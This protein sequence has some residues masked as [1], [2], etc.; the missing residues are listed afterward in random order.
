MRDED[1]GPS[2]AVSSS[3]SCFVDPW[4]VRPPVVVSSPGL[5]LAPTPC[6]PDT[7]ESHPSGADL[8]VHPLLLRLL[9]AGIPRGGGRGAATGRARCALSLCSGGGAAERRGRQTRSSS[10]GAAAEEDAA[11][12]RPSLRRRRCKGKGTVAA[13]GALP[14]SRLR[15]LKGSADVSMCHPPSGAAPLLQRGGHIWCA[16]LPPGPAL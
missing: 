5:S 11:L 1:L 8:P 6:G 2:P 14:T 10:S 12:A 13:A 4:P 7:H 15:C 3:S 16:F 9:S